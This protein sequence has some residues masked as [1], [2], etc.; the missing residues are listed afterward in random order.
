MADID[1]IPL[2]LEGIPILS[3]YDAGALWDPAE[4]AANSDWHTFL[5]THLDIADD[6][7]E[8]QFDGAIDALL[9]AQRQ[10]VL[11]SALLSRVIQ[12]ALSHGF[13][14]GTAQKVEGG[15][16]VTDPFL[17]DLDTYIKEYQKIEGA[18][19][20]HETEG[21]KQWNAAVEAVEATEEVHDPV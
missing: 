19:P 9:L 10:T 20:I 14:Q 12:T 6:F 8:H 18:A 17:I 11:L 1:N 7:Y 16:Q 4:G 15:V 3:S 5:R 21:F 2:D 13:E